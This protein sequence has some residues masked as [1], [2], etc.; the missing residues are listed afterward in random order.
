[1]LKAYYKAVR[2][3]FNYF[4]ELPKATTKNTAIAV[5]QEPGILPLRMD[6]I[7]EYEVYLLRET[8][9]TIF[10]EHKIIGVKL[11]HRQNFSCAPILKHP[12]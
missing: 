7:P 10:R 11:F 3:W 5:F 2:R 1:L 4:C 6:D 12:A 8:T 9:L